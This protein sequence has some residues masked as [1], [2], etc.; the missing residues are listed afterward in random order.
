MRCWASSRPGYPGEYRT[1]EVPTAGSP[2]VY[3]GRWFR[4]PAPDGQRRRFPDPPG[5]RYVQPLGD[6]VPATRREAD[7]RRLKL[8]IGEKKELGI[9]RG[10]IAG[11]VFRKGRTGDYVSGLLD[12]LAR[13]HPGVYRR[14][15]Q[16][17]TAKTR[18]WAVYVGLAAG[19]GGSYPAAR[20]GPVW[21]R[22]RPVTSGCWWRVGP[23]CWWRGGPGPGGDERGGAGPGGDRGGGGAG[24]D[25]VAGVLAAEGLRRVEI[26]AG[27]DG[28]LVAA[29]GTL[30]RVWG[31]DVPGP[32]V[33]RG[34]LAAALRGSERFRA[35]LEGQV[36]RLRADEQRWWPR[37]WLRSPPRTGSRSP[38]ISKR[39]CG[40]TA[41]RLVS[42]RRCSRWCRGRRS[43]SSA[44]TGRGIWWCRPRTWPSAIWSPGWRSD[45][46][47]PHG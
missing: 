7:L 37:S 25:V 41:W 10:F 39:V 6:P 46:P 15:E 12:E 42:P 22:R 4:R 34:R 40:G 23:G 30:A 2:A 19:P 18:R 1:W 24:G 28:F 45:L 27:G 17:R 26:A 38:V 16:R 3:V 43:L 32:L 13:K 29:A 14:W 31:W 47:G 5:A 35:A 36:Q 20:R 44:V 9:S 21:S 11:E 33:L 8:A